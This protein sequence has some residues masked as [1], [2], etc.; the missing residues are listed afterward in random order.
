MV[1]TSFIEVPHLAHE[2]TSLRVLRSVA[3]RRALLCTPQS[4]AR[5]VSWFAAK[6]S[7][8]PVGALT[9]LR[10]A[11]RQHH[12]LRCGVFMSSASLRIS[13]AR[14]RQCSGSFTKDDGIS[15]GS[16]L[17]GAGY[18][19]L[20]EP[21]LRACRSKLP[22]SSGCPVKGDEHRKSSDSG[23]DDID[24]IV[25]VA[26]CNP[27]CKG[28]EHSNGDCAGAAP[29]PFIVPSSANYSRWW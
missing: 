25:I 19:R 1:T 24:E 12:F 18:A 14:P 2:G 17:S 13:S 23:A 4:N 26:A 5:H 11:P 7:L 21:A 20:G 15:L 22:P 29:E 28:Q 9:V 10:P 27:A 16:K 6:V 3:M 8:P